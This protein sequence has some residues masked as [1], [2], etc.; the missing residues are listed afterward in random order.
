M[1]TVT[2]VWKIS[3]LNCN[4]LIV[5][6]AVDKNYSTQQLCMSYCKRLRSGNTCTEWLMGNCTIRIGSRTAV[7]ELLTH[8][9]NGRYTPR[10]LSLAL[11]HS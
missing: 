5:T 2:E 6:C 3:C 4:L 7:K 1:L 8:A 11:V 10:V 9:M